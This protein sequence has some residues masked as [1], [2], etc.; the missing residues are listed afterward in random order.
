MVRISEHCDLLDGAGKPPLETF[1]AEQLKPI[2]AMI[3]AGGQVIPAAVLDTLPSLGAII[4]YGTG[5]DGVDFAETAKRKI[6]VGNSPAANAASV[7]D[8]AL[9]LMLAVTRRLLS[10]DA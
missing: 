7:A 9:T 4:C 3:T 1:S 8:L 2:R 5:Y 10:G 6:L